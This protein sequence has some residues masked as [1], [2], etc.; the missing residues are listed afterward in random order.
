LTARRKSHPQPK[1]AATR[2][3][4]RRQTKAAS[5][6]GP[7]PPLFPD[8]GFA[9]EPPVAAAPVYLARDG[10]QIEVPAILLETEH[11]P[12]P[13]DEG[14]GQ[15]HVAVRD[16]HWLYVHWDLTHHQQAKLNAE[17]RHGHLI[18]RVY[19]GSLEG[20]PAGENHVH[21]QSRHWFA[22]VEM[23]GAT[24]FTELGFY[25]GPEWRRVA[26]AGPITTPRKRFAFDTSATFVSIHPDLPLES[27]ARLGSNFA[28][29][30]PAVAES[31]FGVNAADFTLEQQLAVLRALGVIRV[32]E[33]VSGDS[34]AGGF[35]A[36]QE[37]LAEF[38]P[39]TEF[40]S[41]GVGGFGEAAEPL[42]FAGEFSAS[43]SST[44]APLFS[45]ADFPNPSS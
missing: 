36:E 45:Q 16:P 24:Y 20:E 38:F 9:E 28:P 5:A 2:P 34:G 8:L 3:R 12:A 10:V 22:H 43:P 1:A 23:P 40:V 18:V 15:L 32:A 37:G 6:S 7:P 25:A 26:T 29:E 39:E 4:I 19:A 30:P 21:P 11:P 41:S 17:S 44:D 31:R 13:A 14:E 27:Q 42:S 33:T 35:A